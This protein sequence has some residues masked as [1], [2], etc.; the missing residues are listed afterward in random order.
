MSTGHGIDV[1]VFPYPCPQPT[2][3]F[4]WLERIFRKNM[5]ADLFNQ[6]KFSFCSSFVDNTAPQLPYNFDDLKVKEEFNFLLKISGL[7]FLLKV[8]VNLSNWY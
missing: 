4:D 2:K 7:N 5:E 8:K 3:A 6:I 1:F